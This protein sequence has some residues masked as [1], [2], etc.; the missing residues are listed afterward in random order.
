[1]YEYYNDIINNDN[2]SIIDLADRLL[3]NDD[4]SAEQ[5]HYDTDRD[6]SLDNTAQTVISEDLEPESTM[7]NE[8]SNND[9]CIQDMLDDYLD[10]VS[11]DH[12]DDFPDNTANDTIFDTDMDNSLLFDTSDALS[13]ID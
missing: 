3:K 10:D 8:V 7:N 11:D 4:A 2:D 6:E 12:T 9:L 5:E 13:F 1:M